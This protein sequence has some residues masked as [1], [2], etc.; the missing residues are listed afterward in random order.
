M[1][2]DALSSTWRWPSRWPRPQPPH[3]LLSQGSPALALS[4]VLGV[5]QAFFL[6]DAGSL[7]RWA[8]AHAEY[9]PEQH[10]M[11]ACAVAEFKGLRK[12]ERATF[13]A[14][15]EQAMLAAQ[16]ERAQGIGTSLAPE[17]L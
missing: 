11:L 17:R 10:A 5:C 8:A 16:A 12:R 14:A 1:P 15:V 7:G 6:T 2:S 9:A 3:I 13:V 4:N